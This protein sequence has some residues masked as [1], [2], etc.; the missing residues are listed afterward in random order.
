[1]TYTTTQQSI[2]FATN[3]IGHSLITTIIT[4]LG[5]QGSAVMRY[6]MLLMWKVRAY[7][8]RLLNRP[9]TGLTGDTAILATT[10]RW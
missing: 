4:T 2:W 9:K 7:K 10:E 6:H 3:G 8:E 5:E 1:M